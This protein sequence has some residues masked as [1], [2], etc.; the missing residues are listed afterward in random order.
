MR[1][2]AQT[3]FKHNVAES[4]E[5]LEE[6][7]LDALVGGELDPDILEDRMLWAG[8]RGKAMGME[9]W[10][11]EL[12]LLLRRL[13][14]GAETDLN[15]ILR[16][17]FKYA[18]LPRYLRGALLLTVLKPKKRGKTHNTHRTFTDMSVL[19]KKVGFSRWVMRLGSCKWHI[20]GRRGVLVES[21][22]QWVKY[23]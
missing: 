4:E 22:D 20:S 12:L 16:L 1:E 5:W 17:C 14:S 18:L 7:E 19:H 23:L 10:C 2:V 6:M 21:D 3:G 8:K 15:N 11:E 9:G 13:G